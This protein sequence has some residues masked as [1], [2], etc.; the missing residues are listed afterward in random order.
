[1]T[2]PDD[3]APAVAIVATAQTVIDAETRQSLE[4]M[5]FA[6]SHAALAAAGFEMSDIDDVVISGN[7]EID[8][9]VIS[10]MPSA[11]PSGGVG[12]DTTMIAS[13]ADHALV[14]AYL[15]L[16]ARQCSTLLLVGWAKPSESVDPDRAELMAAEP[17]LLRKVG[18][19]HTIA[20]AM[21]A[22][23]WG[24]SPSGSPVIAWPLSASDLPR[25]G[26]SVY[27][28]VLAVE[29]AFPSGSEDA[30]IV[31]AG[32][33]TMSYELGSRAVGDLESLRIA[34]AQITKRTPSAAPAHWV[35]AE[36]GGDSEPVVRRAA[37]ELGL[38]PGTAVN[39]SGDLRA[40]PTSPYVA[41]LARM[42]AAVRG[43]AD[44]PHGGDVRL[45]AGIGFHGFAAQGATV[46]V[47]AN[48]KEWVSA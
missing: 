48:S 26:D 21:Q 5:I 24:E 22:S 8:G 16:M 38:A 2:K 11:G 46:M 19:N 3:E 32:W 23:I 31:D 43:L 4:E 30:W 18:M 33:T 14:Y 40:W 12:R 28:A 34:T 17:F 10:V 25:R 1:M 39:A 37:A 27:A 44:G 47:F 41:G 45:A 9:R 29:G 7:D 15:R 6:T 20:A 13:S 35:L 36:I 42:I